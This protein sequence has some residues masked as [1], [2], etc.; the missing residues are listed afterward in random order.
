MKSFISSAR[1]AISGHPE[2]ALGSFNVEVVAFNNRLS[3]GHSWGR[4]R[5][6]CSWSQGVEGDGG[7]LL[8]PGDHQQGVLS[9]VLRSLLRFGGHSYRR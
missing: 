8:E 3:V 4:S 7:R 9:C 6:S 1:K 5:M 2:R